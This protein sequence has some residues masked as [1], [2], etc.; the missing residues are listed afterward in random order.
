M[1][2]NSIQKSGQKASIS[3]Q[4]EIVGPKGGGTGKE[5]TVVKGEP[6]PPTPK[7]G[8]GFVIV[9]KTKHSPK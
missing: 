7:S 1:S 3:G 5:V 9:D 8:Q 4:Y 6:L 2:K